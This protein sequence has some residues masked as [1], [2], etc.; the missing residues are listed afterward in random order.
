[1]DRYASLVVVG[2]IISAICGPSLFKS[3]STGSYRTINGKHIAQTKNPIRFGFGTTVLAV[4]A[5]AGVALL[6]WGMIGVI[7]HA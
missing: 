6:I 7:G 1:M 4:F 3:I 5:V 2:L